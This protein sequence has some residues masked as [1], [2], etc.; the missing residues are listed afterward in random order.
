MNS[1]W[2]KTNSLAE[3][4]SVSIYKEIPKSSWIIVSLTSHKTILNCFIRQSAVAHFICSANIIRYA[5]CYFEFR[6]A[7]S[8]YTKFANS[9][10]RETQW[11]C[12]T[13]FSISSILDSEINSEWRETQQSCWTRFSISSV[14]DS[15]IDSQWRK[16]KYNKYH[17]TKKSAIAE[18]TENVNET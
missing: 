10:W 9:E 3:L 4:V 8:L 5:P 13:C 7:S 14:L 11:S 17:V 16:I 2:R 1:E 12:W 6:T 15:E 18:W